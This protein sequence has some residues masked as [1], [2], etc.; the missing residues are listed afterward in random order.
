[1]RILGVDYGTVRVGLAL[2]D[3]TETVA[4]PLQ[5]L[6]VT[7]VR[8]AARQV[9]AVATENEAGR[10]VIGLPLHMSGAEGASAR[11]ARDLADHIG[12]R[13]KVP[14]ETFDER[15]TTRGAEQA[16]HA[17][18]LSSRAQRGRL[19]PVAAALMLQTYL[20]SRRST[21]E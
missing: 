12:R 15:L 5:V 14:I 21:A 3:P 13:T 8:D 9:V 6:T 16:L 20:D 17:A 18:G 19:D 10:I 4:S 2:S 1:M 7:G 11:A